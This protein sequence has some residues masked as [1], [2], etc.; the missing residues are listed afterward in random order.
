[1]PLPPPGSGNAPPPP[2]HCNQSHSKSDNVN[3]SLNSQ[4]VATLSS[5]NMI[6]S[7]SVMSDSGIMPDEYTCDGNSSTPPLTWS[8]ATDGTSSFTLLIHHSPGPD[9]VKW[10]W[11]LYDIPN[12]IN[13]LDEND[14]IGTLGN[15]IVNGETEYAP[16][17]SSG[18]GSK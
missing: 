7:S 14:T 11:I 18:S 8:N 1:M 17:C 12:T 5:G 9:D 10:Y 15:N 4:D 2:D 16:P 13:H 6:L 3:T